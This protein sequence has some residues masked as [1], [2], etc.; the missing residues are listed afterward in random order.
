MATCKWC[1]QP[2]QENKPW[3]EFCRTRCQQDWHLHQRKLE[4]QEK[5]FD[6]LVE[7]ERGNG[8][9][10]SEERQQA[11]EMLAR[12]VKELQPREI[13]EKRPR[14]IRRV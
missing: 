7:K 11:K 8:N 2:F 12:I 4:R 5:L 14:F 6:K 1:N 3:Q 13:Q 10:T 9:G